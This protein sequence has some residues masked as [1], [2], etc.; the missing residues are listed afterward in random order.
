MKTTVENNLHAS[1][2]FSSCNHSRINLGGNDSVD[3]SLEALPRKVTLVKGEVATDEPCDECNCSGC[4]GFVETRFFPQE[5]L[6]DF[7]W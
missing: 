7:G 4:T 6:E 3:A 1:V 5:C 2:D